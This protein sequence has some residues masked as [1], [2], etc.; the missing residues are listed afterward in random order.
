MHASSKHIIKHLGLLD[1]RNGKN[2]S[3]LF[4]CVASIQENDTRRRPISHLR[5]YRAI[6]S[7]DKSCIVQ[8]CMSHTAT[9]SNKQALTEQIG[10]FLFM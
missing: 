2:N 8:L 10:Q 1:S 4:E 3:G 5:F 9:L 7:C 6:L